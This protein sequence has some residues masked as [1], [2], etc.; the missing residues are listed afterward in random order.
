MFAQEN[1]FGIAVV[2]MQGFSTRMPNHVGWIKRGKS[3]S[4]GNFRI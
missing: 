1:A 3:S 2:S 4:H